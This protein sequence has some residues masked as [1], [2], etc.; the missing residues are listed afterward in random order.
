MIP[1]ILLRAKT[2]ILSTHKNSVLQLPKLVSSYA[3]VCHCAGTCTRLSV[4]VNIAELL[5]TRF[6]RHCQLHHIYE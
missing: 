3:T 5:H 2:Q 4:T 6:R 1:N